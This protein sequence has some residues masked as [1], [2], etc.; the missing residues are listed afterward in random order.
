MAAAVRQISV[1]PAKKDRPLGVFASL[2]WVK[3]KK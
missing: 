1:Q 2:P 3:R